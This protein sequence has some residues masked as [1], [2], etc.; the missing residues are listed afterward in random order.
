MAQALYSS[1]LNNELGKK[2]PELVAPAAT[3]A[4]LPQSSLE[5]LFAAI[6]TGDFSAVPGVTQDVAAA[7][8]GALK[9]AYTGSFRTVFYATIPFSA[10]LLVGAFLVP[11]MEKYL[12]GNVAKKLRPGG[13]GDGKE[14]AA[15]ENIEHV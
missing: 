14:G 15:V 2:T 6:P 9:E 12:S 4:G 7:V 10:I 3:K 5:A 1:I 8:A 11:N 13:N